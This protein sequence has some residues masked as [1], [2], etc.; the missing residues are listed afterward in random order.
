[1][2]PPEGIFKTSSFLTNFITGKSQTEA[3]MYKS[4]D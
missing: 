1:M 3:K 2:T 4:I